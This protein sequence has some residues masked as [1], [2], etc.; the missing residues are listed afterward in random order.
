LEIDPI[1]LGIR[2]DVASPSFAKQIEALQQAGDVHGLN[3]LLPTWFRVDPEAVRQWLIPQKDLTAF[4]PALADIACHLSTSG[5]SA[6]AL[7]WADLL[8]DPSLREETFC[9]IL[10]LGRRQGDFNDEELFAA[11]IP[12]HRLK[13]ILSGAEGD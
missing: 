6:L 2:T 3:L 11:D 5:N 7:K 12:P 9:S 13:G 10:A 8:D 4:Q 1:A